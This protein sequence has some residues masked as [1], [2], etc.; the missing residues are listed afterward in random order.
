LPA[1]QTSP[2]AQVLPQAPQLEGSTLVSTHL[3][4]QSSVPPPQLPVHLPAL[5]TSPAA[6]AVPQVPQLEGSK[7]VS[8]QLPLQ[9]DVPVPQ[10]LAH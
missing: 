9:S 10:L 5:Q 2:L 7:S 4:L 3:P 8:T 1:E 6:Q